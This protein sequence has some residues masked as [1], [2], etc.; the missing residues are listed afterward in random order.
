M[1]IDWDED[2][3]NTNVLVGESTDKDD[4][5]NNNDE[6]NDKYNDGVDEREDESGGAA[7]E[8]YPADDEEL[9]VI[10]DNA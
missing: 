7:E 9:D 6:Y 5:D 3:I 1:N 2:T 8:P 10:D 4:D